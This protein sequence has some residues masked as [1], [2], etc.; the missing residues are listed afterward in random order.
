MALTNSSNQEESTGKVCFSPGKTFQDKIIK[1]YNLNRLKQF[2]P[3]IGIGS[4][5]TY[6]HYN[7]N[8][9]CPA[10]HRPS[11][12]NRLHRLCVIYPSSGQFAYST[13]RLDYAIRIRR[14]FK[15]EFSE[16]K[17]K[18]RNFSYQLDRKV[19][20]NSTVTM[21]DFID[22]LKKN[23]SQLVREKYNRLTNN[24]IMYTR[25]VEKGLLLKKL[26]RDGWQQIGNHITNT[27]KSLFFNLD[28]NQ[29]DFD[30]DYPSDDDNDDMDIGHLRG[31][32]G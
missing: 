23:D 29:Y 11:V 2:I 30:D 7:T 16:D 9:H 21:H 13:D 17:M 8:W 22:V 1:A 4:I 15:K 14:R 27:K 20:L 12:I 5:A 10:L 26:R 28:F 31:F 25:D 24:C 18:A 6:T 32:P 3:D 19:E